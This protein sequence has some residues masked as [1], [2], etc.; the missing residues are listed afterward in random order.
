MVKVYAKSNR[1]KKSSS[2]SFPGATC[3]GDTGTKQQRGEKKSANDE[4]N[5]AQMTVMC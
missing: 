3:F 2:S 5:C 1:N 4:K